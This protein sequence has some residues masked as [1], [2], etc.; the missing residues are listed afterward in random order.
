MKFGKRILFYNRW[1]NTRA[2]PIKTLK[3]YNE[4]LKNS[5]LK[6]SGI[7]AK[8]AMVHFNVKDDYAWHEFLDEAIVWIVE[9]LMREAWSKGSLKE[10]DQPEKALDRFN[11]TFEF[12][13]KRC[14]MVGKLQYIYFDV[15][16]SD[17][18]VE[19]LKM[20]RILGAEKEWLWRCFVKLWQNCW[21][22]PSDRR[23]EILWPIFRDI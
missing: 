18:A 6:H 11:A 10:E 19:F 9:T 4:A 14:I 17:E 1:K 16:Y 22:Q 21:D 5:H 12:A 15:E 23:G 7:L 3:R 2:D 20:K 8:K 13:R